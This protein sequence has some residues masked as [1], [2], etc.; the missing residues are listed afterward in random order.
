MSDCGEATLNCSGP[1]RARR[2][3]KPL[4]R[5]LAVMLYTEGWTT[6]A[7]AAEIGASQR[8]V[9]AAL[10]RAGVV[11]RARGRTPTPLCRSC[12]RRPPHRCRLCRYCFST[13]KQAAYRDKFRSKVLT[14]SA[15]A[16]TSLS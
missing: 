16:A 2:A 1:G 3:W 5:D 15:G 10:R 8:G 11:I 14:G 9:L 13:I 7:I 12:G 6:R 4:N